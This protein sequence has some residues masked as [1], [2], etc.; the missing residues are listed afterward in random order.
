MAA[1]SQVWEGDSGVPT[2]RFAAAAVVLD[3]KI[4]VMGGFHR[5]DTETWHCVEMVFLFL[6]F[7]NWTA[8][9]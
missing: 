3:S 1:M 6:L 5:C 4:L 7:P 9:R 8:S 2:A